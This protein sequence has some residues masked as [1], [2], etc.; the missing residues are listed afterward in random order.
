MSSGKKKNYKKIP[1]S[2]THCEGQ[3]G[4]YQTIRSGSHLSKDVIPGNPLAGRVSMS[5]VPAVSGTPVGAALKATALSTGTH[6][7]FTVCTLCFQPLETGKEHLC[8]DQNKPT[9]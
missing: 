1:G 4:V 9:S 7:T 5:A 6:F 2:W 3:P 8:E